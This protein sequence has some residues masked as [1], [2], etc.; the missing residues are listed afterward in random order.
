MN[1]QV[2]K[3]LYLV[4]FSCLVVSDSSQPHGLQHARLPCPSPTPSSV[5]LLSRVPLFATPRTAALQVSLSVT[6][7]QSLLKLRSI[8]LVMPSKHLIFCRPLLLLPTVFPNIQGLY[9]GVSSSYSL[10]E[11]LEFQLQYFE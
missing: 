1:F 3:F 8:E 7:S 2:Q 9:Q 4:Q 6:K 11:V 5:Q 10:A